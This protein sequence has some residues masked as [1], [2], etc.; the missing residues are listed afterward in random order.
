MNILHIVNVFFVVPFF[1]GDQFNYLKNRGYN[2]FL[3]C[4]PDQNL[5]K[6]SKIQ[7]FIYKEIPVLKKIS[8]IQ[9]LISIFLIY[10]YILKNNIDVVNGHTPKGGLLAMIASFIARTPKRIYF[11]H[12]L[13]FETASGLKRYILIMMDRLTAFLSTQ[14]VN[15]SPS[16]A[17]NSLIY[18]LNPEWKQVLLSKGTCTGIDTNKFNRENI[19]ENRVINLKKELHIPLDC[20]IIGFSGRFVRDKGIIE[21]IDA[22]TQLSLK[23]NNV[24]LLLIGIIEERDAIPSSII[25]DIN[26]NP[27]IITTG[28]VD[29]SIIQNYYAL[30][31]IYI[32]PSYR[33]GFPTSILEASAMSLPV[34]TT[35]VT[36][37]IDAIIE[38]KTGIFVEHTSQSIL[39]GIDFFLQDKSRRAIYGNAGRKFVIDSFDQAIVWREIEKLYKI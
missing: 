11:R 35:K 21:L 12:G 23:D 3:I 19:E 16:V 27:N 25:E 36:G 26:N 20:I 31:D 30:M 8:P 2:I 10:R 4:S 22:F 15:V 1:F 13:V 6:Q 5:K 34:I 32:L 38:N 17:Q 9:D 18:K 29:N 28:Y 39:T 33:E 24:Y 7:G 37:C 14:I